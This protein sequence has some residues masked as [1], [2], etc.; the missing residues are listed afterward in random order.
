M[1]DNGKKNKNGKKNVDPSNRIPLWS[2]TI[3]YWSLVVLVLAALLVV[4]TTLFVASYDFSRYTDGDAIIRETPFAADAPFAVWLTFLKDYGLFTIPVLTVAAIA[5]ALILDTQENMRMTISR[6]LRKKADEEQRELAR[7][8]GI[9]VGVERGIT[10]GVARGKNVGRAEANEEW[11]EWLRRMQEA[12]RDG[13]PFDEPPPS[14]R[15]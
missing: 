10:V 4:W 12:Q 15:N 13:K 14:S 7:Q 6:W 9:A 2:V 11:D 3:K 1:N 5:L 8:E